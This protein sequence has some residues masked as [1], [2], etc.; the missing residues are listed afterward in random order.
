MSEN[1][2]LLLFLEGVIMSEFRMSSDLE[3][4]VRDSGLV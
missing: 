2:N 4:L 1:I 3:D